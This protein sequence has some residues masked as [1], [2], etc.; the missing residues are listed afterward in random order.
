MK[1]FNNLF[2]T[3]EAK[4]CKSIFLFCNAHTMFFFIFIF[5]LHVNFVLEGLFSMF[6]MM[7]NPTTFLPHVCTQ[8]S[9]L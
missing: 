2:V 4:L 6:C 5:Y 3:K 8:H 1:L 9:L 7:Y